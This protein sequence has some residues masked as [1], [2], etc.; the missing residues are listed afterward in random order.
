[1]TFARCEAKY[2]LTR[3][4]YAAIRE[5]LSAMTVPDRHAAYRVNNIYYDNAAYDVI[6]RSLEVPKP[7]YKEKLRL[8]CYDV[9]DD[10]GGSENAQQS[11][12]LELKKK[13]NG[14]VYKRRIMLPRSRAQQFLSCGGRCEIGNEHRQVASEIR[15]F[16]A[17]IGDIENEVSI[18]YKR[19]ALSGSAREYND[20]RVTFDTEPIYTNGADKHRLLP[21]NI[22]L[23]EIKSAGAMP[24]EL[25][26]FLS[27][28]RIFPQGFSKYGAA[29]T[30]HILKGANH[31]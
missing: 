1:M 10:S 18:S 19:I 23:L 31:A 20:L 26:R 14:I 27:E 21:E 22:V 3:D 12:F 7:V 13:F 30:N 28:Q 29:F 2:L 6:R 16:L 8:R 9:G 15:A 11:V 24:L 5:F 4:K 17:T 25:A